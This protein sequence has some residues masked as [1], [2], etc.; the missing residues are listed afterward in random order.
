MVWPKELWEWRNRAPCAHAHLTLPHIHTHTPHT[1]YPAPCAHTH[2]L[3]R[4]TYTQTHR[5]A[6]PAHALHKRPSSV[7]SHPPG[8]C[9]EHFS[10]CLEQPCFLA[11]GPAGSGPPVPRAQP[12]FWEP[13]PGEQVCVA[14]CPP[15]QPSWEVTFPH[16]PLPPSPRTLQPRA[17]KQPQPGV[18]STQESSKQALP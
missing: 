2:T 11:Q 17:P 12:Q 16:E 5:P 8:L 15:C 9:N 6:P 1:P 3:P 13:G 4:P 14:P 7:P 10:H 18:P